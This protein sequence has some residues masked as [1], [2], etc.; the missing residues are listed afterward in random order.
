M[1]YHPT[2][3]PPPLTGNTPDQ[4]THTTAQPQPTSLTNNGLFFQNYQDKPAK[5]QHHHTHIPHENYVTSIHS[6]HDRSNHTASHA[7]R[8]PQK[9]RC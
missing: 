6:K 9:G 7:C 4:G 3:T 8:Q 5:N 1:G 2:A